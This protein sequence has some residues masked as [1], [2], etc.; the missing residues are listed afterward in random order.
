MGKLSSSTEQH[1]QRRMSNVGVACWGGC[2]RCAVAPCGK[3]SQL[4]KE[5]QETCLK[6]FCAAEMPWQAF[7]LWGH[8]LP[9]RRLFIL[10]RLLNLTA[11]RMSLFPLLLVSSTLAALI[12]GVHNHTHNELPHSGTLGSLTSSSQTSNSFTCFSHYS[13]QNPSLPSLLAQ[14]VPFQNQVPNS[15]SSGHLKVG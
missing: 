3:N 11:R 10:P 7:C 13:S 6:R 4:G 15:A 9:R 1:Y 2:V 14:D 12:V 8:C 5:A